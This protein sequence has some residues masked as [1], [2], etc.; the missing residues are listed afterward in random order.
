MNAHWLVSLTNILREVEAKEGLNKQGF[1]FREQGR[2]GL[3]D[4]VDETITTGTCMT[5]HSV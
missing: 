1:Y 4:Q 5:C 3:G 2:K